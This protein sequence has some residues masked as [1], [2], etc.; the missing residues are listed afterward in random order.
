MSI[1]QI[2]VCAGKVKEQSEAN[3]AAD[4]AEAAATPAATEN[5]VAPA[6]TKKN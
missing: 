4:K 5:K 1:K 3:K 6:E 2:Q